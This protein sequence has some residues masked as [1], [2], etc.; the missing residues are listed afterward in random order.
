MTPL[1]AAPPAVKIVKALRDAGAAE[2]SYADFLP[3]RN[4]SLLLRDRYRQ[5]RP[6]DRRHP[7][8]RRNQSAASAAIPFTFL[9]WE[10]MLDGDKG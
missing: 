10:G 9:S 5:P 6:F 3:T 4:P 8:S 2:S 7:I 1:C